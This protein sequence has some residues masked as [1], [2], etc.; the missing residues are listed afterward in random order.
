MVICTRFEQEKRQKTGTGEGKWSSVPDLSRKSDVNRVQERE[1]C[2]LYPCG[3]VW[4]RG[5]A[6]RQMRKVEMGT[7]LWYSDSSGVD[8]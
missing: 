5:K 1:K 2:H 6:S 3:A 8:K 4:R 7:G